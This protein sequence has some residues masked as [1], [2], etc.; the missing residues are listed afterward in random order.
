MKYDT[1]QPYVAAYVLIRKDGKIPFL[2]RSNTT[3]LNGYYGLA[4]SGK[5]EKGE[6]FLQAA[7]REAKEEVGITLQPE[8]LKQ[9]MIC[10][11]SE[12]PTMS[13]VDVW[14]EAIDWQG[15]L[16]NAEPDTHSAPDWLDPQNLPENIMPSHRFMLQNAL[17]GKSY[18]EYGWGVEK[19]G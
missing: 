2:L 16:V 14:F 18:C 6:T 11:R 5:V 7:V 9:I 13:W 8:D 17:A 4:P 15:E 3:W 10:H 12:D 19:T 1:A